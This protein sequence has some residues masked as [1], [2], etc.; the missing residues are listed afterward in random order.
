MGWKIRAK[1]ISRVVD[2]LY[3][4][5][6]SD[7]AVLEAKTRTVPLQVPEAW[8][9]SAAASCF[10]IGE[11]SIKS[12]YLWGKTVCSQITVS[13]HSLGKCKEEAFSFF[14]QKNR[15]SACRKENGRGCAGS[16]EL[17]QLGAS[18]EIVL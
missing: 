9:S 7:G 6:P 1:G 10:Q 13:S 5:S 15:N 11:S 8:I 17:Q 14:L 12:L 3:I 4:N 2:M 16:W 18:T